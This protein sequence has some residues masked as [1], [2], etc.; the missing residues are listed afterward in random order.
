M[1]T[2]L[3]RP[4]SEALGARGTK[5][6]LSTKHFLA[7]FYFLLLGFSEPTCRTD[8]VGSPRLSQYIFFHDSEIAEFLI[9]REILAL[10]VTEPRKN[11]RIPAAC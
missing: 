1:V 10:K 8:I 6:A 4:Q 7:G 5:R 3:L 9:V 2:V 11:F